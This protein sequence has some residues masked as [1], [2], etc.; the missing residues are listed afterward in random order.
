MRHADDNR[1]DHEPRP[2]EAADTG[3]MV[4]TP[5]MARRT[6]RRR[7]VMAAAG[8]AV[9]VGGGA[10]VV[11]QVSQGRGT[12]TKGDI[13]ALAPIVPPSS[14]AA[15]A[16]STPSPPAAL[17]SVAPSGVAIGKSPAASVAP[18]AT[19][20]T[21]TASTTTV[22]VRPPVATSRATV[23]E[24][25]GATVTTDGLQNQDRQTLKVVSAREDL[26]G[27]RE[28]VWV[29]DDG[30]RVGTSRCTQNFRI[31]PG[32]KARVRPTLLMCWRTSAQRS[33]YTIAVDLD[34]PPSKLRSVA[35]INKVWSTLD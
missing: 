32:S 1:A 11:Q 29:A 24:T 20:R 25:D 30:V 33:V 13:G 8:L 27:K 16:P 14:P 7:R 2:Q 9:L 10:L 28:L 5:A 3:A 23:V 12:V 21:P 18:S 6:R 35:E 26:T 31:Q 4:Y 34:G 15:S 17:S 22:H 19:T